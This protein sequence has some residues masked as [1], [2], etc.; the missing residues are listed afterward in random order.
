MKFSSFSNNYLKLRAPALNEV[1]T[2]R[3]LQP[4]VIVF[5]AGDSNLETKLIWPNFRPQ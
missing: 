5:L 2:N 4:E 3:L 1:K